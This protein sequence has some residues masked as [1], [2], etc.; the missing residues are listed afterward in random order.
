MMRWGEIAEHAESSLSNGQLAAEKLDG[1]SRRCLSA[2]DGFAPCQDATPFWRLAGPSGTKMPSPIL[3][4]P[5]FRRLLAL[6]RRWRAGLS[7]FSGG[8]AYIFEAA[9][10]AAEIPRRGATAWAICPPSQTPPIFPSCAG[11]SGTPKTPSGSAPFFV[12]P[13]NCQ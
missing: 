7:R 5:L 4:R 12:M 13:S 10:V 3:N 8:E 11:V 6:F 1:S 9:M 2:Q